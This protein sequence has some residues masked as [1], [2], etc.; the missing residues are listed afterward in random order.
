[1]K[2]SAPT[3]I[4]FCL[5]AEAWTYKLLAA[6]YGIDIKNKG[7]EGGQRRRADL[8]D[9]NWFPIQSDLVHDPRR[10]L[11]VLLTNKLHEAIAL[12]R[13]RDSIFR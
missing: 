1:M 10:I 8:V 3:S 5:S 2:S 11:C 9:S 13:L 6:V 7:L 4:V 12:M